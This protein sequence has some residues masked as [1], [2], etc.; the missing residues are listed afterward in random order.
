MARAKIAVTLWVTLVFA[1]AWAPDSMRVAEAQGGTVTVKIPR[2]RL[3]ANKPLVLGGQTLG[4]TADDRDVAIAVDADK[5]YVVYETSCSGYSI[6]ESGSDDDNRCRREV[7]N[8]ND[9]RDGEG[10][11]RRCLRA[12]AWIG[13]GGVWR[14]APSGQAGRNP[15]TRPLVLLPIAAAA[16]GGTVLA[17]RNDGSPTAPP[18]AGLANST[19]RLDALQG[20]NGCPGFTATATATMTFNPDPMTGAGPASVQYSGSRTDYANARA[21]RDGANFV[22][23][24]SGA[25]VVTAIRSF[26]AD[27]TA[28]VGTGGAVRTFQ[29]VFRQLNGPGSPCNQTYRQ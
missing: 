18:F 29:Q 3:T 26:T 15:L 25:S 14:D 20:D 12:V 23:T 27:L 9:T 24:A 1:L 13:K 7:A 28:T 10:D 5:S 22:V 4:L 17:L 19:Y 6:V 16:A 21:V 11:C 8:P 2:G